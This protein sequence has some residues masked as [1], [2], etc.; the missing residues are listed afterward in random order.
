M[1][2]MITDITAS[3]SQKAPEN[4]FSKTSEGYSIRRNGLPNSTSKNSFNATLTIKPTMLCKVLLI[5]KFTFLILRL[6]TQENE[7]KVADPEAKR[8]PIIFSL[9][10]VPSLCLLTVD[11]LTRISPKKQSIM[12]IISNRYIGSPL[13]IKPSNDIMNGFA[14]KMMYTSETGA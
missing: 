8:I 5:K 4:A 14:L 2:A 13:R 9:E 11:Q 7:N 6:R 3:E 1:K 12:P 10:L